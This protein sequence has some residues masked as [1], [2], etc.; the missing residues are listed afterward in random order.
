MLLCHPIFR[1][2]IGHIR[3]QRAYASWSKHDVI[4]VPAV[5]VGSDS[6]AE[7]EAAGCQSHIRCLKEF[8]K[9]NR[10]YGIVIEDDAILMG[11]AWCSYGG[12][13]LFYP[14]SN[15]RSRESG[16]EYTLLT[17]AGILPLYGS[18]A[19]IASRRYAV[20]FIKELETGLAPDHADIIA[21]RR[22]ENPRIASYARNAV[23][24]DLDAI[25]IM[26]EDRRQGFLAEGKD[27]PE[28]T[29][30]L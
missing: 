19:Y 24:H 25:S 27:R 4:D 14:F 3:S 11:D 21:A 20:E 17:R 12:Y 7:R 26:S 9:T 23:L 5:I 18:Q 15:N 28:M 8:L 29:K 13:D 6:L 30:S 1:I 2:D 10:P 22:L 16:N